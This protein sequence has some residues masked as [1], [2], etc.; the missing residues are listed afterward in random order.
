[1]DGQV[2]GIA[3][4]GSFCCFGEEVSFLVFPGNNMFEEWLSFWARWKLSWKSVEA[5]VRWARK[6]FS[7]PGYK[8]EA[9]WR[10][11]KTKCLTGVTLYLGICAASFGGCFSF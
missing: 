7:L 6:I 10:L 4:R 2:T 9:D 11:L 3:P 5:P 8:E 1:M